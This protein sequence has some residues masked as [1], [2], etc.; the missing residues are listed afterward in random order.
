MTNKTKILPVE[1][2]DDLMNF[3]SKWIKNT[4]NNEYIIGGLSGVII[5]YLKSH[6]FIRK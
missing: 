6:N 5:E 2:Y 1:F 3:L 4:H